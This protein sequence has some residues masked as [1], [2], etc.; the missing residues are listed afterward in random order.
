MTSRVNLLSQRN[1]HAAKLQ[2]IF[3]SERINHEMVLFAFIQ[4]AFEAI[5]IRWDNRNF[6]N[7]RMPFQQAMYIF[8]KIPAVF[9]L[10]FSL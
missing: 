7:R 10:V 9:S 6:Q 1:N 4:L 3:V 5:K 2:K 8:N